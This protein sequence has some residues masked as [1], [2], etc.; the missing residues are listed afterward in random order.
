[1]PGEPEVRCDVA[2]FMPEPGGLP[3]ADTVQLLWKI[4]Q[5]SDVAGAGFTGLVPDP[6]NVEAVT[7]MAAALG[8]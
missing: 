5:L 1:M 6:G 2:S 8:L 7:Q 4:R 3:L